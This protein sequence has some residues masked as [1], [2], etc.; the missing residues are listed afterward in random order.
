MIDPTLQS[1]A[2]KLQVRENP[3]TSQLVNLLQS[4]RPDNFQAGKKWFTVLAICV[5]GM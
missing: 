1:E 4:G 3:T 5:S 2:V